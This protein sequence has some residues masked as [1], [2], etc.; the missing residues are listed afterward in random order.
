MEEAEA[1]G[2]PPEDPLLLFLVLYGFFALNFVAFNGAVCVDLADQFL[3][4]AEKHGGSVPLII[5]NRLK[6]LSSFCTGD[7]P[8]QHL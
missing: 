5:G 8:R 3:V 1:L 2:E 4:L 7:V 6:G